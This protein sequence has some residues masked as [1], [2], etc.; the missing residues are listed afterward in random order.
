M[1]ELKELRRRA[2]RCPIDVGTV[3]ER[4]RN[5]AKLAMD[6][7]VLDRTPPATKRDGDPID[8]E[9]RVRLVFSCLVDAD[10]LDAEGW[11]DPGRPAARQSVEP[12]NAARALQALGDY[13]GR[14]RRQSRAAAD[15]RE[16]R[17]RVLEGAAAAAGLDPGFFTLDVPTGGG[18]TLASLRFALEHARSHNLRRIIYVLPY[19]SIIEQVA[20]VLRSALADSGTFVLEHHSGERKAAPSGVADG[21]ETLDLADLVAENWDAPVVVTTSVQFFESLFSASAGQCRKLHR[22]PRSVIILDECQVFPPGLLES[23][24]SMLRQ[25]VDSYGCSVVFSTATQPAFAQPLG[26]APGKAMLPASRLRP[27]VSLDRDIYQRTRRVTAEWRREPVTWSD[28]AD[29]LSS[30]D[31]AM[32]IVNTRAAARELYRLLAERVPGALHLS[33]RLCPAHRRAVLDEVRR[34]LAVGLPCILIATQLV[35]AGV[36]LDFPAVWRAMAPLDSIAQAAGRCNREGRLAAG[37][38]FVVFEPADASMPDGTYRTGAGVTRGMGADSPPDIGDP[39]AF[40]EYFRRLYNHADLDE[41]RVS[42]KRRAFDFPRVDEVYR[43][44]EDDTVPLVV[45]YGEAERLLE[46]LASARPG[47]LRDLYRRLASVTVALRGGEYR[48]AVRSGLVEERSGQ[49]LYRGAYDPAL[50]L[51]LPGE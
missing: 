27:I 11:G 18:K 16:L 50:G 19:L 39:A 34:R 32:V 4:A 35:E 24:I 44:I 47:E 20:D 29:E 3:M 36:D 5:F 45:S 30:H 17:E 43:L 51:L 6:E 13:L 1:G 42:E 22:I 14:V 38:R 2:E 12:L 7:G 28:L 41:H 25:L 37:G 21:G 26:P 48:A 10:R 46:G 23:T 33:T 49:R 9:L 40:Q 8:L 31:Q 15:I